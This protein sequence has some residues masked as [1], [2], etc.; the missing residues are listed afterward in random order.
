MRFAE[1]HEI[2]FYEFKR[3]IHDNVPLEITIEEGLREFHQSVEIMFERL[4]I[5][6]S[7][8]Y[9]ICVVMNDTT[10]QDSDS[11]EQF[12]IMCKLFGSI[13]RKCNLN[14]SPKVYMIES[15]LPAILKLHGK[16]GLF[17]ENPIERA[18][19]YIKRWEKIFSN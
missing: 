4:T 17:N 9:S 8:F 10:A 16:L 3:I 18:H 11:I 5:L 12:N 19:I 13:W 6:T 2:I 14:V 7:L 15:H 1:R